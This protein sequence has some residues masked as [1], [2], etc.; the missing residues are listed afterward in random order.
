MIRIH[1]LTCVVFRIDDL[2]FPYPLI[3]ISYVLVSVLPRTVDKATWASLLALTLN[4]MPVFP[5]TEYHSCL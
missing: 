1:I 4:T 2:V 5:C 3:T